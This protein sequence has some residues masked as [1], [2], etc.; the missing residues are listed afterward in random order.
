MP[1]YVYIL[2]C[3]DGSFYTGQT[4]N[5]ELRLAQHEEGEVPGYVKKHMRFDLVW[6]QEFPTRDEAL[7]REQ[8]IK[9][10]SRRKKIALIEQDWEKLKR[11]SIGRERPGR[12]AGPSTPEPLRGSSA[13]GERE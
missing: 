3:G 13:Q 4:D 1:F 5:L 12:G 7:N 10:W 9:G 8:Q 2:E 11:F 6:C